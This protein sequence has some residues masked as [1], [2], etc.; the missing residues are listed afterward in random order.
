MLWTNLAWPLVDEQLVPPTRSG[1][2][3]ITL[4]LENGT[5]GI[6]SR[7]NASPPELIL[8][9]PFHI[10]NLRDVRTFISTHQLR[11]G[12]GC[13]WRGAVPSFRRLSGGCAAA[14]APGSVVALETCER[15][16]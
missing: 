13:E 2:L 15:S 16:T 10:E 3:Y 11:E 7:M 6:L 8:V 9:T 4:A 12:D 5:A 14:G 1:P